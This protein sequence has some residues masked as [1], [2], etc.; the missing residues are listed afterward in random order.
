[1]ATVHLSSE[2]SDLTRY[3]HGCRWSAVL[4]LY[5]GAYVSNQHTQS[6][7]FLT[8]VAV[9][10]TSGED[11]WPSA[12]VYKNLG[13]HPRECNHICF[14]ALHQSETITTRNG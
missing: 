8:A 11:S 7:L 10:I 5:S 6:H 9:Q 2:E 14:G 12:V 13:G 1:M 3:R 4:P